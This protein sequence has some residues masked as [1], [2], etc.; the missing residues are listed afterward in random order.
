MYEYRVTDPYSLDSCGA[1][2]ADISGR[3]VDRGPALLGVLLS[4][5]SA[6][7]WGWYPVLGR[8]LQ[9]REI[10]QP[11]TA[12]C[13]AALTTLTQSCCFASWVR[14]RCARRSP[15]PTALVFAGGVLGMLLWS[16]GCGPIW[17]PG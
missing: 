15:C 11:S 3:H 13:L 1:H 9:T 6:V 4:V 16:S 2:G 14:N 5:L 10:G 8:Y 12:A 7:M 17:S